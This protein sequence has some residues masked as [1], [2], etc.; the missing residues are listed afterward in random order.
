[1]KCIVLLN[2]P[3]NCEDEVSI[4]P[5]ILFSLKSS[6]TS[7]IIIRHHIIP[8]LCHTTGKMASPAVYKFCGRPQKTHIELPVPQQFFEK[9]LI[10]ALQTHVFQCHTI[11]KY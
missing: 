6:K 9:M 1:M 4:Y 8:S 2:F 10:D 5:Y 3:H 11:S 7:D